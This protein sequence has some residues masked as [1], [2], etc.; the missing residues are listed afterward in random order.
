MANEITSNL[1]LQCVSGKVNTDFNPG[2]IQV[3]YT[4]LVIYRQRLL[5]TTAEVTVTHGV[6]SPRFCCLYNHDATNYVE[7]GTTTANYP[8]YLRPSS[9]PT[10]FE[11]GPS[12]TVIYLKANTASCY[13]E[14][15]V[16]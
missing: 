12:K 15:L 4:P 16:F 1:R 2:K 6:A 13:V 10:Q 7:A 8:V 14:V 5:I 11:I 9:V 3:T